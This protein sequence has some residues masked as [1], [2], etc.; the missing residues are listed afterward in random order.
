MVHLC[1]ISFVDNKIERGYIIYGNFI[2][3]ENQLS[4]EN[5]PLRDIPF[6][7]PLLALLSLPLL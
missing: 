3:I 1:K 2:E 6:R 5:L 4:I 7:L